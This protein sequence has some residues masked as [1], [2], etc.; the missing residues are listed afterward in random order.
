M[1][2]ISLSESFDEVAEKGWT[3]FFDL[4]P[5]EVPKSQQLEVVSTHVKEYQQSSTK[6]DK[7][8]CL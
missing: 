6:P 3:E 2:Y 4:F 7:E 5:P 1:T 8:Q